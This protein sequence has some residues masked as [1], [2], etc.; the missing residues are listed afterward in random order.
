MLRSLEIK[1]YAIIDHLMINF[2]PDLNILT[3]ETGAGKS[4][5]IG[6]INILLGDRIT[7]GVLR[8]GTKKG[9]I[10]G[11]FDITKIEKI[12]V[13]EEVKSSDD[14]KLRV[15][16]EF[17]G[18]GS[19]KCFINDRQYKVAHIK[20][21]FSMIFDLHGQHQHQSLMYPENYYEIIDR[22]GSLKSLKNQV[23]ESFRKIEKLQ[24]Q[25]AALLRKKSQINEM[26]DFFEFQLKEIET[27]DPGI[28]EIEEL[29]KEF[30]LLKNVEKINS[31]THDCYRILYDDVQSVFS[32][33]RT[34]LKTTEELKDL[35][36]EIG[37]IDNDLTSAIVSIEESAK[38]LFSYG[39]NIESDPDRLNEINQ[40][41]DTLRHLQKKYKTDIQGILT[42]KDELAKNLSGVEEIKG[43]VDKLAKAIT[44][45]NSNYTKLS[46]LLSEKRIETAK[47]LRKKILHRLA[48]LGMK[49]SLFDILINKREKSNN[50]DSGISVKSGTN[51]FSGNENGID[52]IQFIIAS[53]KSERFLPISQIASGGELSRL[54]LAI[55]AALM[56][57]DPIP[58]LVFDEIDSGISGRIASA[59]G[60]E[61]NNL[62]K[63]HQVLCITHLPQIAG[64]ADAHYSVEKTEINGRIVTRIS[65]LDKENRI[66]EIAK[67]IAG[68]KVTNIHL[69]SAEEMI[70]Q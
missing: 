69:K 65:D 11:D 25:Q 36:P 56:E 13:L 2:S 48:Y 66:I 54:M 55:K 49:N 5:I 27:A 3:G 35:V 1:N 24:G 15:R 46:K 60:K 43:D 67:L 63:V 30:K 18:T 29:E 34:V 26:R 44:S 70:K 39:K 20:N 64:M 41:L 23:S 47:K 6:A 59:V 58:I 68:D 45:E 38:Y 40:R 17:Y 53:G 42:L 4:I 51:Y 50:I 22:F 32:Q 8:K 10:E 57:S 28:N 31:L 14:G 9:Y 21:T 16:R 62:S 33:I 19:S 61:L 7:K 12:Q 52:D 37:Q